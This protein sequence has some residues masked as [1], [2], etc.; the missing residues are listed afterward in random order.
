MVAHSFAAVFINPRSAS[1]R[2]TEVAMLKLEDVALADYLDFL[3]W[4]A[5][6][7]TLAAAWFCGL[8]SRDTPDFGLRPVHTQQP[9][10][11]S[12]GLASR[13]LFA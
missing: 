10:V 1:C 3:E 8:A 13:R 4:P 12:L 6:A 7:F 5:M 11:D 9:A 2:G